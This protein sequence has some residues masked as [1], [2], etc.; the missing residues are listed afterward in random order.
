M[1]KKAF[2]VEAVVPAKSP[3]EE[4]LEV[5]K[6]TEDKLAMVTGTLSQKVGAFETEVAQLRSQ[7]RDL[8]LARSSQ[9]ASLMAEQK[10]VLD[11]ALT[12]NPGLLDLLA[13][14]H[15]NHRVGEEVNCP[16]CYLLAR[17]EWGWDGKSIKFSIE[18][19][20]YLE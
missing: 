7:K 1:A 10:R 2:Q 9:K 20:D 17:G 6:D 8:E 11:I 16:R 4:A 18:L 5:L 15:D 12:E 3:A 19:S 14:Q 13:P